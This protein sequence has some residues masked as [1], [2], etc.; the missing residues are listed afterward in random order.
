VG[1]ALVTLTSQSNLYTARFSVTDTVVFGPPDSIPPIVRTVERS[2]RR[3][4]TD[5]GLNVAWTRGRL[6]L[7]A[8]LGFRIGPRPGG[9]RATARMS[10]SVG[11]TPRVALVAGGGRIPSV[12]E[13]GLPAH[14]FAT[15]G[16][17]FDLAEAV[18]RAL[19]GYGV[20]VLPDPPRFTLRS[21]DGD[22]RRIRVR[23][24]GATTV[25]LVGDFTDWAPFS[26]WPTGSGWWEAVCTVPPGPH[27]L[28]IRIDGGPWIVPPDLESIEDEFS[29][30]VGV[31]V[32]P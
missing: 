23:A 9:P 14:G 22:R 28:N 27:R 10:G 16:L 1:G 3:S 32:A 17:R 15:L 13:Q 26:M 2:E 4:Y 25:D 11:I 7:G 30:A 8:D 6:E 5:A 20:A 12:P 18:T 31:L 29:G 19:P 21:I 24:P